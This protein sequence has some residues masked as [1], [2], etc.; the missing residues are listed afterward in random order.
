MRYSTGMARTVV[1][2]LTPRVKPRA[3]AALALAL[4]ALVAPSTLAQP[5]RSVVARGVTYERVIFAD[6]PWRATAHVARVDLCDPS[7]ELRATAPDEG[8]VT[9]PAWA[10]RVGALVAVNGDY[11]DLRTRRPLGPA[12][13]DGRWWPDGAREHRDA[14]FVAAP[15]G[16]VSVLDATADDVRSRWANAAARVG[17]AWR[18]VVAVRERVLVDGRA[19]ESD[20]I[21]HD[22]ARHP[23]TALGLDAR[24]HTLWMVVVEGRREQEAGV[25]V[26]GLAALLRRLGARDGLKLDGGGSSTMYLRSTGVVNR[27]SDGAPRAVAT[28]LG[29]VR[30]DASG[31]PRCRDQGT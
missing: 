13:G 21:A 30:R 15:G 1:A 20:T 26:A 28:H 12:R 8:G 17:D 19:V 7:I 22:G 31:P 3:G 24:R 16:R 2:K 5:R 29:V 4:L 9:V 10:R 6:G 11:F 23:R 25:S 14:L 18:E 27:P